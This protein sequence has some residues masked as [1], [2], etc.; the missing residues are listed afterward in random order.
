MRP[1]R[2]ENFK[3]MS[4]EHEKIHNISHI[5]DFFSHFKCM[6]GFVRFVLNLWKKS[7]IISLK[8][9][10]MVNNYSTSHPCFD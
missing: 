2:Y 4:D 5:F 3:G 8:R 6:E 1:C 10:F 7:L 9:I